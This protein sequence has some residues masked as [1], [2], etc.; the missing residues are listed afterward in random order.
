MYELT[1][2]YILDLII[3]NFERGGASALRASSCR[4]EAATK[5]AAQLPL[6]G[7]IL[8]M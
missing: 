8:Q 5:V 3:R 4:P 2:H 6:E 7:R 1:R